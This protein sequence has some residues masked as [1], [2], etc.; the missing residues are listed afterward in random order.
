MVVAFASNLT[1]AHIRFH[2]HLIYPVLS[3]IAFVMRFLSHAEIVGAL[4]LCSYISLASAIPVNSDVVEL[5]IRRAPHLDSPSL[6]SPLIAVRNV[7]LPDHD[8]LHFFSYEFNSTTITILEHL[9]MMHRQK[10]EA[11]DFMRAEA[12][13]KSQNVGKRKAKKCDRKNKYK[14]WRRSHWDVH[15]RRNEG[16]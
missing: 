16:L 10:R 13:E 14:L 4:G 8:V 6:G 9:S 2:H 1:T 7:F 12:M 15:E 11:S 5:R 3:H